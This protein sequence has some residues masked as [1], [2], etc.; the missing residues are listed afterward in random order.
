MLKQL[1][2]SGELGD[3]LYVYGNRQNLGTIRR[4]ENALWSL[5]V[6][7]LSVILHLIGEEPAE[8]W[9]RYGRPGAPEV[10]IQT[11]PPGSPDAA[12]DLVRSYAEAGATG[13]ILAS[14]ST[15]SLSGAEVMDDPET[16]AALLEAAAG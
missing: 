9:A 12:R 16:V 4:D 6:H 8:L 14:A 3:V 5:G 1:V 7:D 15:V 2:E 11:E 10:F 13:L